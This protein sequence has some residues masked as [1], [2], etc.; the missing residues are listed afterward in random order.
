ML[1]FYGLLFIIKG[2]FNIFKDMGRKRKKTK[3]VR[4][5]MQNYHKYFANLLFRAIWA[6]LAV[7]FKVNSMNL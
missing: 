7:P 6:C 2:I 4:I 3:E 1:N 5:K